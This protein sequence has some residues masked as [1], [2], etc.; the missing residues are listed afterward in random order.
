[1]TVQTEIT[2]ADALAARHAKF[3]RVT[4][5]ISQARRDGHL[6]AA[7]SADMIELEHALYDAAVRAARS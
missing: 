2:A 6:T 4:G 3:T 1:M 7:E 5:C